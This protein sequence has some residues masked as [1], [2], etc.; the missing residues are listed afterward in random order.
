MSIE[1]TPCYLWLS[2]SGMSWTSPRLPPSGQM[3]NSRLVF[4][5]A[6]WRPCPSFLFFLLDPLKAEVVSGSFL[7]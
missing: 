5:Q 3:R 2:S 7:H 1:L 6:L 4:R